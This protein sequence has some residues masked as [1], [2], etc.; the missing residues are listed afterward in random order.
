MKN[1]ICAVSFSEAVLSS[2]HICR[3]CRYHK[4][5][6][7]QYTGGSIVPKGCCPHLYKACYPAALSLLYGASYKRT[8]MTNVFCP[9]DGTKVEASVFAKPLYP[10]FLRFLKR[11]AIR[12]LQK[13]NIPAEFP[14]NGVLIKIS[15]VK[16]VCAAGMKE[17][18]VFTFNLFNKKEL[19]PASF[20]NVYT[21]LV[22]GF[23]GKKHGAAEGTPVH[24]PDPLG[25][26][27][28]LNGAPV[29]CRDFFKLSFSGKEK[30]NNSILPAGMCPLAFYSA[31]PYITTYRKGGRFEWVKEGETV[32]VQCPKTD[33]IVMSISK[34]STGEIVVA[35]VSLEKCPK[36]HLA[37]DKFAFG[38]DMNLEKMLSFASLIPYRYDFN[39]GRKRY[40]TPS[41]GIYE[42]RRG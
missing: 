35:V 18:N 11:F 38:A 41:G 3:T 30:L 28:N 20:Y 29:K 34:K 25:L 10:A 39:T 17:G 42:N 4:K 9:S 13:L 2:G 31:A 7:Q 27:Y 33:G 8:A 21:S 16:G 1:S 22:G 12:L 32:R 26:Y 14:E 6:N 24:C 23:S 36:K 15:N 5:Q 19:C 37:G 40:R